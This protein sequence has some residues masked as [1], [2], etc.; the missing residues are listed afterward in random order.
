MPGA[1]VQRSVR[2]ASTLLACIGVTGLPTGAGASGDRC[3]SWPGEPSPLPGRGDADPRLARWAVLRADEL[4][5]AAQR[6]EAQRPVD[7]HRVWQHVAC[8]DPRSSLASEGL[9]RTT[10]VRVHRPELVA[11]RGPAA[12]PVAADVSGALAA[13]DQPIA[14]PEPA[15]A[16]R[17]PPPRAAAPPPVAEAETTRAPRAAPV[18]ESE[19]E[20]SVPAD[21]ALL[22][23]VDQEIAHSAALLRGARF[24][25]AID[26]AGKARAD[27]R[28]LTPTPPIRRRRARVEVVAAT[29]AVALGRDAEAREA[30][31]RALSDDPDLELDAATSPKV[32][33]V[34]E[35]ARAGDAG[36]TP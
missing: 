5:L 20:A 15:L 2:L 29:A 11:S 4:A 28:G 23:L 27:L 24:E 21:A 36:S 35:S 9:A 7:A 19:G 12:L 31:R 16:S 8:L 30:F 34:F 13:L 26:A 14:V 3:V 33:R 6:L 17:L 10:P 18:A 1:R 25:E 32:R 22:D